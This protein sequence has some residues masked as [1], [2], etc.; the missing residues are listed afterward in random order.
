[1]YDIKQ[2][3]ENGKGKGTKDRSFDVDL[4]VF[5]IY[6]LYYRYS[7]KT[8]EKELFWGRL[9]KLEVHKSEHLP[10]IL[11]SAKALFECLK[12]SGRMLLRQS[13]SLSDIDRLLRI[14]Y[15][16][17]QSFAV[18]ELPGTNLMCI[19]LTASKLNH[20]CVP[21][22]TLSITSID[23]KRDE[24][25][26]VAPTISASV[27]LLS[28]VSEGEEITMSYL[29]RLCTGLDERQN[30]LRQ[31]FLFSC[32]CVKCKS[33][34]RSMLQDKVPLDVD[35]LSFQ[36]YYLIQ[37]QLKDKRNVTSVLERIGGR[38]S[39]LSIEINKLQKEENVR[40]ASIKSCVSAS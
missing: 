29:S 1:M 10:H 6:L 7:L 16:N 37:E 26:S 23:P 24:K 38:I 40:L 22:A 12:N 11:F 19:F 36:E 14:V 25:D 31:S 3:E 4:S 21:N 8:F 33:E 13:D 2:I 28:E 32:S 39:H 30:I 9:L 17:A 20:S 18:P 34:Q 27:I 15:F 5:V 35:M